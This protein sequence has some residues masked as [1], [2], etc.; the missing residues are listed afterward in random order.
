MKKARYIFPVSLGCPKNEVDLQYTLGKFEE[1]G[2]AVTFDLNI[3]DYVFI[4]TCSFIKKAKQEAISTILDFVLNK[5]ELKYKVVVGGCIVSLYKNSLI[6]LFPEVDAF[7]EPGRIFNEDIF[8]SLD[9]NKVYANFE[10]EVRLDDDKRIFFKER[11]FEY[12][13]IADGCSRKC[14]YC[15]IP[16]IRGPYISYDRKFLVNQA[17][18]LVLSG[19]KEIVLVAQDVTYYGLDNKDSLLRLLEDLEGIEEIK[20]IRL[21]YLYP[22]LLNEDIIRFI[23]RSEK[24]LPYFDIPLQHAGEKVLRYMRRNPDS[25]KF[26]RLID[27]IRDIIPDSTIRSTF[28][29]GHPGEDRLEFEKLIEFLEKAKLNWA[30]F[31][32]YSRE[33]DT[34][35]YSLK[36]Q[37]AYAEKTKRLKTAQIVQQDITLKWRES[38]IGKSF[39]VLIEDDLGKKNIGRS[40]MEA[41]DIDSFISFKGSDQLEVGDFVK[42]LITKNRGFK[43]EGE[44]I[45]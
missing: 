14:S 45:Q 26:L 37:V 23:S 24:V 17:K 42:I 44:L 12:L 35:S 9:N 30:G 38:L 39:T 40:Y 5:N 8:K 29:V 15:L 22:D 31:F 4:N 28:I 34:F 19:K 32:S 13:K 20:W 16:K 27:K 33:E 10:N 11:P 1:L 7:L 25:D 6:E 41:P 2:C 43:L 21:L 36:D 3:A 18:H